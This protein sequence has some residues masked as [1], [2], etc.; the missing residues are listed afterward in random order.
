MQPQHQ[1]T[2]IF[3]IR[4]PPGFM[5]A[6]KILALKKYCTAQDLV[7]RTLA[8]LLEDAGVEIDP[9]VPRPGSKA[10]K[11]GAAVEAGAIAAE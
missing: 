1:F 2:E 3:T 10:T 6:I 5:A 4:M 8:E 7:R 11:N 9:T